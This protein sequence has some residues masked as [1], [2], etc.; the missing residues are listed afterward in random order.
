MEGRHIWAAVYFT[1]WPRR[2]CTSCALCLHAFVLPP[3]TLN[4]AYSHATHSHHSRLAPPI[5]FLHALSIWLNNSSPLLLK[6]TQAL[7]RERRER[8]TPPI[9]PFCNATTVGSPRLFSLPPRSYSYPF[10]GSLSS[11]PSPQ[12]VHII[13]YPRACPRCPQL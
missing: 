11:I 7:Q 12:H 3:L 8:A 9:T 6:R 13:F 10:H 1:T 2:L 5:F 4:I